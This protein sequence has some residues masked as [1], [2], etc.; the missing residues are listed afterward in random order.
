[1]ASTILADNGVSSGSAGIKT[2]ADSTG[3]LALQTTTA[4]GTATT[5]V[6]IDTSQNVGIGTSSPASKLNISGAGP[7]TFRINDTNTNN[8]DITNNSYLSFTRGSTERMRIDSSGNLL[9][10]ATSAD[11]RV[12]AYSSSGTSLKAQNPSNV[13]QLLIGYNNTSYNYLDADNN[14]F[15]SG[16]GT[17]RARIDASG[18][19]LV[20]NTN[21]GAAPAQGIQVRG[22]VSN[23]YISIGHASGTGSG[24]WFVDFNYNSTAIGT[25]S[26]NGT[27]AVAYNT[28]SDY[29]LKENVQ[30][31]SGALAKV[32]ALKPCTYTW[33]SA[34]DEIGEGFI[35]HELAEVC[36]QAV[37]GQK[38]A[39]ETYTDDEGVEQ[40]RP[41]YQ[42]IDTSFLVAT[43][44]AAI[45]E[46]QAQISSQAAVIDAQQAELTTLTESFA[47]L[48]ARIEAL[49]AK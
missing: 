12:F 28:T 10:G 2:S 41:K 5:A 26:Q 19:L 14:I 11:A 37:T 47:T 44:T 42:S 4:G 16:N 24:N 8:W 3:A 7:I 48:T 22:A 1:M 6:T 43:L 15:R 23:S 21:G 40:T 45:Q 33:K 32:A 9:V 46:Q 20:G 17:E 36:P 35:A 34:P 29:R 27:T 13:A 31:L 39:V 25:I 18:N 49:E 38:D 30:P